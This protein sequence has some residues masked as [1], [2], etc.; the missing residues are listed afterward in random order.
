MIDR[1][2]VTPEFPSG[3]YA[4]FVTVDSSNTSVPLFPFIQAWNYKGVVPS[5]YS[6]PKDMPTGKLTKVF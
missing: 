4:Y 2:T 5:K 6:Y 1:W 3:I